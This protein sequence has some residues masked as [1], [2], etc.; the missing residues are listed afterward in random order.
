MIRRALQILTIALLAGC[1][2]QRVNPSFPV[3]TEKA[4]E[5]LASMQKDR[6]QLDRPLVLLGGFADVGVGTAIMRTRLGKVVDDD[7]III[8]TFANCTSFEQ[9]R[10]RVVRAVDERFGS[11][12]DK[13]RT[14]EVDV[15]G[16]SMGGLVGLM[17]SSDLSDGARRLN[18]VRLFTICSPLQGAKLAE[19]ARP[20]LTEMHR[21][22]R[23]GSDLYQRLGVAPASCEV[24]SYT[25]L[26]DRTV[27]EKYAAPAGHTA[28]WLDHPPMLGWH[29]LGILDDR[30]LA[31]IARR[32]RDEPPYAITPP[33]PLPPGA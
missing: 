33:A 28:W 12:S 31:D 3:T 4:E 32:L 20:V 25:R 21:D 10:Q 1:Q 23:P 18:A 24:Y 14:V 22:M 5:D 30:I 19:F 29:F 15:I 17:A 13:T 2:S 27:G 26:D 8:V 6:R 11:G 9:C 16:Q 7:R